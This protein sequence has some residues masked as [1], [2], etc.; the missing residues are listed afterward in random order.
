MTEISKDTFN[1]IAKD[2]K[3]IKVALLGTDGYGQKGLVTRV[4]VLEDEVQD[5][6]TFKQKIVYYAA[7][8]AGAGSVIIQAIIYIL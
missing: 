7:G 2:V 6:K 4:Q 5:I 3:E 8:S 1:H